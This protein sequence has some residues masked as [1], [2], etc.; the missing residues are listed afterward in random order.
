MNDIDV[1]IV[2]VNW[3]TRDLLID[4][5]YSLFKTIKSHNFEIIVVDNASTDGST[6]AV[7][8][9]FPDVK[10][11]VN[12]ENLGFAKANNIGLGVA[13]GRYY[14]LANS[15]IIALSGAVDAII[16]YLDR[17]EEVGAVGP[18][19]FDEYFQYRPNCRYFPSLKT[20][21][22]EAFFLHRIPFLSRLFSGRLLDNL[23]RNSP[24]KVDVLSG[25]FFCFRSGIGNRIGFLDEAF[26]IY[27]EDKDFCKR[28]QDIGYLVMFYPLAKVIHIAG[29][30]S[31]RSPLRFQKE[32]LKSDYIYWYKHNGK[33]SLGIFSALKA[34]YYFN[35]TVLYFFLFTVYLFS[36]RFR[37]KLSHNTSLLFHS[38]IFSF[39]IKN[40]NAT[41]L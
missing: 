9:F 5:I 38:F 19:T 26:F 25:C 4:C 36:P 18:L 2:I 30:S 37:F 17:H 40:K 29:A 12:S 27:G 15:D 3:N 8:K 23:P 31:S 6:E 34:V 1:S 33:L 21:F 10:V 13:T 35:R 32:M 16:D 28:I 20:A 24:S 39:S 14:C 11:I 22:A 41:R 7:K